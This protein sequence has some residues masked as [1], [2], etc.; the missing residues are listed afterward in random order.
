MDEYQSIGIEGLLF[1]NPRF[2]SMLLRFAPD[3]PCQE[4]Q[5]LICAAWSITSCTNS[6]SNWAQAGYSV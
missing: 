4:T 5:A 6:C 2:P 3:V 1:L